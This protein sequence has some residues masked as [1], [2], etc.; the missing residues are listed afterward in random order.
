MLKHGDYYKFKDRLRYT[1]KSCLKNTETKYLTE[2]DGGHSEFGPCLSKAASQVVFPTAHIITVLIP[3][4][5]Y[6]HDASGP[7]VL[8]HI[9]CIS[10]PFS[11]CGITYLHC[12]FIKMKIRVS[13]SKKFL[14]LLVRVAPYFS[15]LCLFFLL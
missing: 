5:F 7:K 3:T 2:N 4:I 11:K 14:A 6:S 12:S 15:Q 13:A 8:G 9:H 1:A 10:I